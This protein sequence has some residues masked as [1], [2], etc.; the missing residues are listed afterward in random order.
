[1]TTHFDNIA[2]TAFWIAGF[3]AQETER[4][5]AVFNDTLAKKLGGD[6]GVKMVANTPN[7][8]QM[9]FAMVIRTSS[10]DRLVGIA[11]N[12]GVDTVINLG[13]GLDTRPYRLQLPAKLHWI[14]VDFE[15]IIDYKNKLLKDEKPACTIR[16]IAFDLSD[17]H[18]RKKLFAELGSKTQ[19]ALV[20]TEGVIAYLKNEDASQL[21]QDIFA[22]PTFKY[23]VHDFSKGGFRKR[24]HAKE[25]A[26]LLKNTPFLFDVADP[27]PFF[28]KDGWKI[29]EKI[30][31]LDEADRVGR[32][33]P[34]KFPWSLVM[35]IFPR[36]F[37]SM[38]N[39]TYGCVMFG[40]E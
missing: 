9:A 11:V 14:E 28:E 12:K 16:R 25:K 5:D 4:P 19:N 29:S 15:G 33:L 36:W 31:I 3:R 35:R 40:K 34:A 24:G 13:A 26:K 17:R 23:W 22:V 20:I 27:I 10:I 2:D 30:N 8:E 39:K 21:S 38:G 32:K 6:R 37:R 18:G 7:S 1:M